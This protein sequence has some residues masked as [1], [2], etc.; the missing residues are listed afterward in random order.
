MRIA[1]TIDASRMVKHTSPTS[2]YTVTVTAVSHCLFV[3]SD[4]LILRLDA[5]SD[6]AG[7][8]EHMVFDVNA[9]V[10]LTRM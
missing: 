5:E 1:V 9:A 8:S 7:D 3:K 4:L 6:C 10:C 2:A